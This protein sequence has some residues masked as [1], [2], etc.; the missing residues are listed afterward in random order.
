ML[1]VNLF[2]QRDPKWANNKLGTSNATILSHGCTITVL[3][4]ILNHAGYNE[5]P[6]TVNQK[7]TANAGYSNG[8]LLIWSAVPR[9]WP[10]VKF[11][12][13]VYSYDNAKALE[14]LKKGMM[15]MI[16]VNAQPIGGTAKHWIGSLGDSKTYDP[17][18][19]PN[20]SNQ[21]AP[22]SKW[23]ATGMALFEYTPVTN[24]ENIVEKP[25]EGTMLTYLN[26]KSEDEAKSKLKEHLGE[27]NGKCN[28]GATKDNGGYLGSE[29]A[30]A[31]DLQAKNVI[32]SQEN[33]NYA[34]KVIDLTNEIEKL[35]GEVDYI[36]KKYDQVTGEEP[37]ISDS[38]VEAEKMVSKMR[39]T[40]A[41]K[42]LG[43]YGE[44]EIEISYAA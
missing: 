39:V 10:K 23:T 33:G 4:S 26:V 36:T 22:F 2:S 13:R 17:D 27:V 11:I 34:R 44:Q 3:C 32:L 29:R 41:K 37:E 38:Y 43:S 14:W 19:L 16:E 7:L 20:S 35:K 30:K 25:Q 28:W 31:A 24:V 1:K 5:T 8:N 18:A 9:I 21:I 15:P 42:T 12:S 6:A 40:G